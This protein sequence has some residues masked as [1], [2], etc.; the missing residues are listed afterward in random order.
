[1]TTARRGNHPRGPRTGLAGCAAATARGARRIGVAT[2]FSML[3]MLGLGNAAAANAPNATNSVAAAVRAQGASTP[4]STPA[5]SPTPDAPR[6]TLEFDE[7]NDSGVRGSV[8]LFP[9]DDRTVVQIAVTNVAGNH[10]A[11]VHTG[12]CGDIDP[13]PEFPLTNVDADGRSDTVLEV[14][15]EILP[16]GE[17]VVDIHLSPTELGTLI[18]CAEIDGQL[19]NAAGTPVASPVASPSP[20]SSPSPSPSPTETATATTTETET[21]TETA[22]STTAPEPTAEP[23]EEPTETPGSGTGGNQLIPSEPAETATATEMSIAD[24]AATEAATVTDPTEETST[25]TEAASDGTGGAIMTDDAGKGD[26]ITDGTDGANMSG[27]GGV[28]AGKGEVAIDLDGVGGSSGALATV[29]SGKGAGLGDTSGDAIGDGSGGSTM[30]TLPALDSI[31]SGKGDTVDDAVDGT[32]GDSVSVTV[33]APATTSLPRQAGVGT[34]FD[35]S[36]N[37]LAPAMWATGLFALV[38][39][40][41]GLFI[42][43]GERAGRRQSGSL[44]RWVRLGL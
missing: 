4:A 14:P 43:R 33:A 6:L 40:A 26:A 21:A 37:P 23:T 31:A 9:Q 20:A 29:T 17:Y 30:P 27:A 28:T 10:P 7:L 11:H 3:L 39:G 34:A 2:A 13:E 5:A 12:T 19:T 15:L 16:D 32:G 36:A 25:P 24:R 18:A 22:T 35:F 1:M 41:A 44:P 8:T 38:L 42:R